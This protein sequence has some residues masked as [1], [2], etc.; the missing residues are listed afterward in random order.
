MKICNT[1][2][3]RWGYRL[4]GLNFLNAYKMECRARELGM[5]IPNLIEC[6]DSLRNSLHR[7]RRDR[8][9]NRALALKT[10]SESPA[11]LEIGPG[12]GRYMEKIL[13][14]YPQS[15]Y[16]I[17][18]TAIDWVNY[19]RKTYAKQYGICIRNADGMTL[20]STETASCDLVHAHAVFVYLPNCLTLSY[21]DEMARVAKKGGLLVFDV[22]ASSEFNINVL[23]KYLHDKHTFPILFP[24][25][26]VMEWGKGQGLTLVDRFNEVYASFYS[27]Y[28]IWQK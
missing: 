9:I 22:L 23:R 27:N 16:E 28:Y 17:Y 13:S 7:G 24:E 3:A 10:F 12:T 20:S 25:A 19:L 11:I 21:L 14:S 18:E 5:S 1:I 15:H 2:L 8:I 4:A 26:L 6:E